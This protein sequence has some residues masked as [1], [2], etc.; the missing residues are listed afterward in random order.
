LSGPNASAPLTIA[1][2]YLQA[3]AAT[4][5]LST[6]DIDHAWVTSQ[7]GDELTGTPNDDDGACLNCDAL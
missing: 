3:N 2:D 4:L 7:Y 1:A 6:Y 5:G